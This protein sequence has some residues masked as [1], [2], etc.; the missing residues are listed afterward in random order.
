MLFRLVNG[1]YLQSKISPAAAKDL[2]IDLGTFPAGPAVILLS[3]IW[4]PIH[5]NCLATSLSAER[6][7]F[8]C[9]LFGN[10]DNIWWLVLKKP[11]IPVARGRKVSLLSILRAVQIGCGFSSSVPAFD[12]GLIT[13]A[14]AENR[15]CKD[16]PQCIREFSTT[17][18]NWWASWSWVLKSRR[19][20]TGGNKQPSEF[21]KQL[22][23][24]KQL[25]GNPHAQIHTLSR[26]VLMTRRQS[27]SHPYPVWARLVSRERQLFS[28]LSFVDLD[29]PLSNK[30]AQGL[31]LH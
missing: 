7:E 10:W 6:C 21:N 8:S 11:C 22:K 31:G 12:K 13:K 23:W 28:F 30:P 24:N 26:A 20:L 19:P 18:F 1:L 16:F 9:V 5:A 3:S 27:V 2:P 14:C 15:T 25:N 4:S 17:V 29:F